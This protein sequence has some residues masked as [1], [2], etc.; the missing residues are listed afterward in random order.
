MQ[1]NIIDVQPQSQAHNWGKPDFSILLGGARPAPA[2]PL[3]MLG[4]FWADLSN[5]IADSANAPVD[6]AAACVLTVGGALIGNNRTANVGP[7]SEPP[8]IWTALI[9]NPSSGKSP[10]MDPFVAQIE[11]LQDETG[12]TIQIDDASAAAAGQVSAGAPRGLL[13]CN[14]E[15]SAW[16]SRFGQLGGEQFWL[17]AFGARPHSIIRKDKSP[18]HV[19]RL[20]IS[21]LGGTQPD[22]IRAF[23]AGKENRGFAARWLYIYPEPRRG[24]SIA[25][26]VNY[27]LAEDALRRLLALGDGTQT[28]ACPLSPEAQALV[29]PWVGAKRDEAGEHDGVWGEWLGKQGGV[30][31]RLALIL[32]YLWW[33]A[34]APL[35]APPPAEISA[36]AYEAATLFIDGYAAPMA[37]RAFAL[38]AMPQEDK[39]GAKL[40]KLIQKARPETFNARDVRRSAFGPAGELA[41]A[42]EMAV[43]CEALEAAGFIRHIGVR[44]D[45]KAGRAPASYEVNPALLRLANSSNGEAR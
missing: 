16:W 41:K 31:L 21:V 17:K 24:Y 20:A 40:A 42:K 43:A 19:R 3:K 30:A 37:A 23:T 14:D 27:V 29:E 10:V 25:G 15:V 1:A 38:S 44:A 39:L 5:E 11:R 34:D 35:A 13:L 2:F 33:A 36:R 7:W 4:D 26:E 45:G 22:T 32:E 6:Y 12:E 18:L 8:V 9:G 28:E